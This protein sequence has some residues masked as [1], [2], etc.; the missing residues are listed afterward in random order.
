[1]TLQ[2]IVSVHDYT[3]GTPTDVSGAHLEVPD[4]VQEIPRVH[5][6]SFSPNSGPPERVQD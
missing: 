5:D 6:P 3:F 4:V 1:M 2:V